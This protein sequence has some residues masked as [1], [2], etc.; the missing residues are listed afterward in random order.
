MFHKVSTI[1]LMT[2]LPI[3]D[4]TERK[5]GSAGEVFFRRDKESRERNIWK[6]KRGE[7]IYGREGGGYTI[8]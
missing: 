6:E 4:R 3:L 5:G 1:Y 7:K 2:R 8:T